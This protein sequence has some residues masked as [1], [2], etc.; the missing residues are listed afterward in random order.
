MALRIFKKANLT[1]ARTAWSSAAGARA[2]STEPK[3]DQEDDK[4]LQSEL[5]RDTF[6]S[7]TAHHALF[8][9][10]SPSLLLSMDHIGIIT[11]L[12]RLCKL[13]SKHLRGW[14]RETPV[15]FSQQSHMEVCIMHWRGICTS[16]QWGKIGVGQA[17]LYYQPWVSDRL[18]EVPE[19]WLALP[20]TV[21][22]LST[23]GLDVRPKDLR[24]PILSYDLSN[25][26]GSLN[27]WHQSEAALFDAFCAFI[28]GLWCRWCIW[29]ESWRAS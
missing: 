29:E 11:I 5:H 7:S 14:D 19:D 22:L 26:Y 27:P 25:Q 10:T 3:S 24:L 4:D 1:Q 2:W 21:S 15:K 28:A 23:N 17:H 8:S 16:Q 6:V 20:K 9:P 13:H 12:S 18:A